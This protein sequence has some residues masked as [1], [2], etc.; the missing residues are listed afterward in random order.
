M[1]VSFWIDNKEYRLNLR[2]K[3]RTEVEVV[4]GGKKYSISIG[5]LGRDEFL[6][7]INGKVYDVFIESNSSIYSI[8]VKGRFFKIEKK[9]ASQILGSGLGKQNRKD[10]KTSMPGKIVKVLLEKGEK[11]KEGQAVLILEAMKMQNEIKSPRSGKITNIGPKAGDSVE[12]NALLFSV[13]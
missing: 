4:L 12:A 1:K 5:Y 7:N 13:G 10:V 2:E 11:V 8:G 9:S 6:L 3:S